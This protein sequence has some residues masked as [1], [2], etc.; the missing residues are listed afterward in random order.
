M[1]DIKLDKISTEPVLE[2]NGHGEVKSK[3]EVNNR[4][5]VKERQV[6]RK[7]SDSESEQE[8]EAE[9][10]E[11]EA[12]PRQE[13]AMDAGEESTKDVTSQR[14]VVRVC[15]LTH[16]IHVITPNAF[17]SGKE[18]SAQFPLEI[19][20]RKFNMQSYTLVRLQ[21]QIL[22]PNRR[23]KRSRWFRLIHPRWSRKM[24]WISQNK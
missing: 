5:E 11:A 12:E 24:R 8:Q 2:L 18:I 10:D 6:V 14:T 16:C 17:V 1:P 9:E 21:I 7:T 15:L 23:D 13:E 4:Q 20:I 22:W 19:Q 3:R